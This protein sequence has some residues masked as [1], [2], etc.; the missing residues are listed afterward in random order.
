MCDKI[1]RS[2]N[3][4]RRVDVICSKCGV[5]SD[6]SHDHWRKN[7]NGPFYC[8]PCAQAIRVGAMNEAVRSEEHLAKL[9][10]RLAT[11][12]P[13]HKLTEEQKEEW[14]SK[15]SAALRSTNEERFT[16]DQL[17]IFGS[18]ENWVNMSQLE[19]AAFPVDIKCEECGDMFETSYGYYTSNQRKS[20]VWR[21]DK[22]RYARHAVMMKEADTFKHKE[23]SPYHRDWYNRLSIEEKT[24]MHAERLQK[25]AKIINGFTKKFID[26]F[27]NSILDQRFF[28][29]T[30]E[31]LCNGEHW[32]VWDCLIYSKA[33][34]NL[35]MAVDLDGA[36]Y[37]GDDNDYILTDNKNQEESDALRFLSVPEGVMTHIIH[38]RKFTESFGTMIKAL[39]L[40]YDEFVQRQFDVCRSMPFPSPSYSSIELINSYRSLNTVKCDYELKSRISYY[41][42]LNRSLA[43]MRIINHFHP[44]IYMAK[45]KGYKH[46][47]YEAWHNDELLKQCIKNR[48]I[49][50]NSIYPSKILQGFNASRIAKKV[51]VF[52]PVA[53]RLL[54]DQYLNDCDQVFDPFSGFSG[55]MLGCISLGK[56]YIGQDISSIHINESNHMLEYLAMVGIDL[57]AEL[58]CKDILESSGTY[59]SLFTCPPYGDKEEWFEVPVSTHTCDDWIELILNIFNCRKYLFVVDETNHFTK[60]VKD[61]IRSESHF[62]IKTEQVILINR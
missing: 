44:S 7:K 21:C 5:K 9:R 13:I 40:D 22:C 50:A 17:R 29:K 10:Y 35:V 62:G 51:S 34:G 15:I 60:Y 16:D 61:T 52:R 28:I 19:R 53:A 18:Y 20:D 30:E 8:K 25:N 54:I 23:G 27:N 42:Y 46:S 55:R 11:N 24:K 26:Q 32:H 39:M 56:H 3:A 1:R 33:T 4:K 6:T 58:A 31:G 36:F 41:K 38:E 48:I 2:E 45:C 43:G 14:K 47:P 57:S 49:Y 37:H 59:D 12:H